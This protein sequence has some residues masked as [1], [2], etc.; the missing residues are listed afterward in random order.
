MNGYECT[1][2]RFRSVIEQNLDL[3]KFIIYP[4]GKW[5]KYAE[6]I[7]I[8]NGI[9]DYLIT[10]KSFVRKE[11]RKITFEDMKS[12]K[13][14]CV[15]LCSDN[16]GVYWE[17]RNQIQL[18]APHQN[19]VDVCYYGTTFE[20]L[21]YK[22]SDPRIAALES[23]SREIYEKRVDGFVAEAG[24][25]RGD[26]AKYINELFPDRKLYLFDTFEGFV[27]EDA[28]IDRINNF[29]TGSQDWSETNIELV[30]SKMIHRDRCVVRK[31]F[32]P[33]TASDIDTK[34]K[35]CFV[36]LDMDLYQPIY[37]GLK[38]FYPRLSSGGFIFVHDCRNIGY[39]GAR[40]AM[41]DFC[42]EQ[43]IGYSILS[44]EWGSAVIAK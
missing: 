34:Q 7:L 24:V 40:K 12:K 37:E 42:G 28:E 22:N 14:Y 3:R 25:Y 38:F 26:F 4:Y 2:Q 13:D 15:L 8:S 21:K 39:L 27:K 5:G 10:D 18:L 30:L 36:S 35:F 16:K 43:K 33:D 41:L 19:I 1:E 9:D 6:K 44:D 11:G 20:M 32:F 17:L 31:G 29:S 23:C